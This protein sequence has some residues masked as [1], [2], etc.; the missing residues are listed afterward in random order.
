VREGQH[1]LFKPVT[2]IMSNSQ[3]VSISFVVIFVIGLT[4]TTLLPSGKT[5]KRM[6]GVLGFGIFCTV[7]GILFGRM[8]GYSL[9][10]IVSFNYSGPTARIYIVG[11]ALAVWAIVV[12]IAGFLRNR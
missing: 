10:H 12:E 11:V 3:W 8:S 9:A 1:E 7:L 2:S 4:A 5:P 6:L